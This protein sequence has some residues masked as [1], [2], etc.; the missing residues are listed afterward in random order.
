MKLH[1]YLN[2]SGLILTSQYFTSFLGVS[3]LA[4]RAVIIINQL[5]SAVTIALATYCSSSWGEQ[6]FS[7][8]YFLIVPRLDFA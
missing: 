3:S 2:Y 5:A 4:L 6:T 8:N 1:F 7:S